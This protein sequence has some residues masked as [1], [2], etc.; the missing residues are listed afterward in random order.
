MNY[1]E[2]FKNLERTPWFTG[3]TKPVHKGYYE[4]YFDL[5]D[6]IIFQYWDGNGW[7]VSANQGGVGFS[8][9]SVHQ[10]NKLW[11]GCTERF[12]SYS[13]FDTTKT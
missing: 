3:T 7:W 4:R 9:K 11:R 13:V 12:T 10:D 1:K 5:S 6:R 8:F 2:K